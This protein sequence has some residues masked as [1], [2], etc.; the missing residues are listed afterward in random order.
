M[1]IEKLIELEKYLVKFRLSLEIKQKHKLM[2]RVA[3]LLL[4]PCQVNQFLYLQNMQQKLQP[5]QQ[6]FGFWLKLIKLLKVIHQMLKLNGQKKLLKV[7]NHSL[8]KQRIKLNNYNRYLIIIVLLNLLQMIV[9]SVLR[10]GVNSQL[11][12]M[13]KLL[14]F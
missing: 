14:I 1:I 10:N 2:L 8:K 13:K 4:V 3:E 7:L 5:Q 12:L 6:L 9:L 11:K